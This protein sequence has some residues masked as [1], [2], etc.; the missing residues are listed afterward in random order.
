MIGFITRCRMHSCLIKLNKLSRKNLNDVITGEQF[1]S[2]CKS[3]KTRDALK[4]LENEGCIRLFWVDNNYFPVGAV[5]FN[6]MPLYLCQRSELWL[7]RI[8]GFIA[9]IVSSILAGYLL[10]FL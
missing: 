2:V 9:G 1:Q 10:N 8:F 3:V 7:N 6:R 5:C 4:A